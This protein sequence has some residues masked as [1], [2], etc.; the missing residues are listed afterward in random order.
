MSLFKGLALFSALSF[1]FFG[2]AC[3]FDSRMRLEFVRYG[4][5]HWRRTT[6]FLQILGGLG[7]LIG[8]FISYGLAF[9]SAT[10]LAVLMTMGFAVRLR[11]KDTL[12]QTLPSLCYALLNAYLAVQIFLILNTA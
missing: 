6:G 3:L 12:I 11:I 10:G 7:L 2:F 4:L 1:L 9:V 8:I 5:D